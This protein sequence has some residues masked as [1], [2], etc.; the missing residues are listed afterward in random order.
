M[1]KRQDGPDVN[2]YNTYSYDPKNIEQGNLTEEVY[3]VTTYEI[4][5]SYDTLN[6]VNSGMFANQLIS[7]DILTRKSITTNF[8][9]RQYWNN[10]VTGG[11]NDYPL[12]NNFKNRAGQKLNE[13]S[14]AKLKLVFSNFDD[15]NNAVVQS[16]PGSVAQNI[17][18]ET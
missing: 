17:Y 8:D 5:N 1:Y 3:N 15:A 9:Y 18:A 11:L 10:P 14:Q 4:L 13:T 7:V 12:T 16:H 6:A 2:I